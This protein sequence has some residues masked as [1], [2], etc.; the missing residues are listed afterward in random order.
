MEAI[1]KIENYLNECI[2]LHQENKN[3]P[4]LLLFE[5]NGGTYASATEFAEKLSNLLGKEI[6]PYNIVS[7]INP[8]LISNNPTLDP[9]MPYIPFPEQIILHY[10]YID[11]LGFYKSD[12]CT[13][14]IYF[15]SPLYLDSPHIQKELREI[16]LTLTLLIGAFLL[17][18]LGYLLYITL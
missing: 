8:G 10:T 12:R 17:L 14:N 6:N 5:E 18:G 16:K 4:K 1:K 11:E 7:Q 9:G 13:R 2:K 15:Y 3:I